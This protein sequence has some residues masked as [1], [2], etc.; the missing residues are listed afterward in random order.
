LRNRFPFAVLVL[1]V[2]ACTTQGTEMPDTVPAPDTGDSI[3]GTV[4]VVGSAPVNVQVVIEPASGQ[5]I[6]V[7][8]PLAGEIERLSGATI[9]VRGTIEPAP[10]PMV[11]RQVQVRSYEIVSVNGEPAIMGT[12]EGHANDWTLL[13]TAAGEL[14]YLA[15]PPERFRTGQKVWIQG[16]GARIVQTYGVLSP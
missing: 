15:G 13:R 9:A 6:R 3:I 4:R 14:I 16:P 8:G 12:V 11:S 2:T 10:D 1:L 7:A 5:A